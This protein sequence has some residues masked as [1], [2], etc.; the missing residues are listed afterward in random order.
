MVEA[1]VS[2]RYAVGSD[3]D[4]IATFISRVK[5]HRY[6]TAYLS[7]SIDLASEKLAIIRRSDKEYYDYRFKDITARDLNR[8]ISDEGLWV[9]N[10]PNLYHWFRK[11]I[12]L[13][14]ARIHRAILRLEVPQTHKDYLFLCFASIVRA[15]SNADPVPISGLEVTSYMKRK[16]AQ[17]RIINPY[18]LLERS[19]RKSF[20]GVV[21]YCLKTDPSSKVKVSR[22]SVLRLASRFRRTFDA[23]ITSPPYHNAVD[24][25]RRH[26]LEIYWLGFTKTHDEALALM[27]AYLG[28]SR[29]AKSQL[30][31]SKS[32]RFG[33]L[34]RKWESRIASK[35][36]NRANVF[37]HY[38]V[39]MKQAFGQFSSL[40]RH[41]KPIVLVV[42]KSK[43]KDSEIPT[44]DLL[45]ELASPMFTL[46]DCSW[47]PIKNRYMSFSR[48]NGANIDKEYVLIMHKQ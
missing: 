10:I 28:R 6:N 47:Y 40:L 44:V 36:I 29:V 8:T 17:G 34:A 7:R 42:G 20:A 14:L 33:D 30:R 45:I 38:A 1:A 26:K 5:T 18:A 9:P 3:L 41:N 39:S 16:E 21:Q 43:W 19:L 48:H 25:Y 13:D 27:R 15:S 35:S 23:I 12:I 4:P 32:Y 37:R 31:A 24:Y 46:T 22:V 2:G 11:Y